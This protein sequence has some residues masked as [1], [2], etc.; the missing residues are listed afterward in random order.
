MW[1]TFDFRIF[2]NDP[3]PYEKQFS[4]FLKEVENSFFKNNVNEGSIEEMSEEKSLWELV[5]E[6]LQDTEGIMCFDRLN[7]RFENAWHAS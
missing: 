2:S 1:K 3:D 7:M 4:V 6:F 5:A